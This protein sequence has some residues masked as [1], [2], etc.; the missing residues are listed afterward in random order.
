VVRC[1][2]KTIQYKSC[3]INIT[4]ERNIIITIMLTLEKDTIR[5]C[6]MLMCLT[7][8]L[9]NRIGVENKVI[10]SNEQVFVK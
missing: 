2:D 1:V 10:Q 7:L 9:R 8:F 6:R 3:A 4:N 5:F